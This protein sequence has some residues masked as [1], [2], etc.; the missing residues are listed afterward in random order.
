MEEVK[1][2]ERTKIHKDGK[3]A[4]EPSKDMPQYDVTFPYIRGMAGPVDFTPGG[5]RNASKAD[6][7]PIYNNP[8]TMGTRCHQLAHYIVHESPL[9]MLADN[10]T[11][12]EKESECT[13][14][15]ASLP[16]TYDEMKVL[17]GKMGEYIIVARRQG[18]NW[19]VAGETNWDSRDVEINAS[20][21]PAGTYEM[22]AFTDGINADKNATDYKVW[23]ERFSLPYS[24]NQT[25]TVHM[26]SGGGF[27]AKLIYK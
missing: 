8:M 25:V 16:N 11:I 14:F 6:F 19:Y 27:A 23:K 13:A 10:P 9:T 24:I 18:S 2:T 5:M 7:Q 22:T 15:I 20:F 17:A 12:Y 1:W 21:L 4:D 3:S 26:A